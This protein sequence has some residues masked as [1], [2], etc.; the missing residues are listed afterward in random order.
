MPSIYSSRHFGRIRITRHAHPARDG[1]KKC[2]NPCAGDYRR[3][4]LILTGID[5]RR[6]AYA[7]VL[8]NE[9]ASDHNADRAATQRSGSVRSAMPRPDHE[10]PVRARGQKSAGDRR[11]A[12]AAPP[13]NRPCPSN[14]PSSLRAIMNGSHASFKEEDR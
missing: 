10:T 11:Q 8:Y 2:E 1:V 13:V 5:Y 14:I 12:Q 9:T 7:D 3:G 4:A 6:R